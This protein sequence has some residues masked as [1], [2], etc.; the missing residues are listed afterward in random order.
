MPLEDTY[1][2]EGILQGPMPAHGDAASALE[3][4]GAQLGGKNAHFSFQRDGGQFSLLADEKTHDARVFHPLTLSACIQQT[5][6]QVM[7]RLTPPERMQVFSTLRSRE[8]RLG[9]EQQT[10][11]QVVPP[12]IVQIQTRDAPADVQA[13]A[14]PWTRK[15]KVFFGMGA[16]GILGLAVGVSTFFIDYRELFGRALS[17]IRG[18]KLSELKVD[19]ASLEGYVKVEAKELNTAKDV[20]VLTL[21]RGPKWDEAAKAAPTPPA[22]D[23]PTTLAVEALHK[24][25]AAVMLLDTDGR[26]VVSS[27]LPLDGLFAEASCNFS[28]AFG[29]GRVLKSVIVRP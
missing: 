17:N 26:V 11:Y 16:A 20:L 23:W 14:K 25:Y 13:R 15:E 1:V 10:L 6:E 18:T 27:L 24:K 21:S 4:L 9:S 8:Y 19:A 28:I 3:A 5:L 7:S 22:A 29:S 12:G 2:L